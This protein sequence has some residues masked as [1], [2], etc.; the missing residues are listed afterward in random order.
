[1]ITPKHLF[2]FGNLC[3]SPQ[4]FSSVT[5]VTKSSFFVIIKN[6]EIA[7]SQHQ[8]TTQQ[9]PVTFEVP[10]S[11]S[12]LGFVNVNP[13]IETKESQHQHPPLSWTKK[14][15][16]CVQIHGPVKKLSKL[17]R[18]QGFVKNR[19][20]RDPG[21]G[22]LWLDSAQCRGLVP[23]QLSARTTNSHDDG[24]SVGPQ[25][26]R[27]GHRRPPGDVGQPGSS[28]VVGSGSLLG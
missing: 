9:C 10:G 6:P 15:F 18:P 3:Y 13:G 7:R 4:H 16:L 11:S 27:A 28:K 1:M 26:G 12:L 24:P 2:I 23:T 19:Y 14:G 20:E 17:F 21:L 8:N 5:V 25:T 22:Q